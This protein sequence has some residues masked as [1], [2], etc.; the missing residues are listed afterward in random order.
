M[1]PN[2]YFG[3]GDMPWTGFRQGCAEPK[4]RFGLF[5]AGDMPWT[6]FRRPELLL[7]APTFV[8]FI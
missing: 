3:A 8:K 6:G 5:G 7:P 4:P 2:A 1:P